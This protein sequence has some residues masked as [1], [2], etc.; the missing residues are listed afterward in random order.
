MLLFGGL[1]FGMFVLFGFNAALGVIGLIAWLAVP[2]I[3]RSKALDAASG[4][5]DRIL[6]KFIVPLVVVA[7]AFLILMTVF[8]WTDIFF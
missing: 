8:F 4:H 6:A 5:G 2:A 1:F 7:E 3:L